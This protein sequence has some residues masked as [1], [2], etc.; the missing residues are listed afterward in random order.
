MTAITI[1]TTET[2]TPAATPGI[3]LSV[4]GDRGT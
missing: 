1:T 3:L 2:P 4:I